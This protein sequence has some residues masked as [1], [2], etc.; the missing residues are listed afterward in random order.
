MDNEERQ[1]LEGLLREHRRRL[2]PLE[3]RNAQLGMSTPPEVINEIDDIRSEIAQIQARL[4]G[5]IDV[6]APMQ[7][8]VSAP[9]SAPEQI[10][11]KRLRRQALA[12]FYT[13][14]WEQ[15]HCSPN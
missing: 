2:R 4:Y 7:P 10:D 15:A 13:Q 3:L 14:K 5:Q 11:L 6:S 9:M 8:D 1:H 12:A